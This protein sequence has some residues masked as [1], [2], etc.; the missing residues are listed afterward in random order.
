MSAADPIRLNFRVIFVAF[1]R[2]AARADAVWGRRVLHFFDCEPRVR[3]KWPTLTAERL[4][5]RCNYARCLPWTVMKATRITPWF[6][7]LIIVI[8]LSRRESCLSVNLMPLFS[9]F[10][11]EQKSCGRLFRRTH[12][13]QW[14]LQMGSLDNRASWHPLVSDFGASRS[15]SFSHAT[16]F[17]ISV[18]EVSS[19]LIS[20]SLKST[21]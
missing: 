17:F 5:T 4:L 11:V 2:N 21:H 14:D 9:R 18:R 19:K 10:R 12:R 16:L 8:D 7:S 3:S 13:R 15:F 20:I 6:L 1:W